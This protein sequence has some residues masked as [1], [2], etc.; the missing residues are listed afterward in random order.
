VA[1]AIDQQLAPLGFVR[2]GLIWN[3]DYDQLIDVVEIERSLGNVT[4]SLGVLDRYV[5]SLLWGREVAPVVSEYECTVRTRLGTRWTTPWWDSKDPGTG[6]QMAQFLLSEGLPFVEQMHSLPAMAGWLRHP[7]L[8]PTR[9]YPPDAIGY[10]ILQDRIGNHQSS[11]EL[12]SLLAGPVL[13]EWRHRAV[14]VAARLGCGAEGE[15]ENASVS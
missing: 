12:L 6:E 5:Y 10:A 4:L 8:P 9:W 2:H 7:S 13:G 14:E 11:C 1:S 15:P 3:R